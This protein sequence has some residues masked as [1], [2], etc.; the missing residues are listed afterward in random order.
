M[1][2]YTRFMYIWHPD[3][4]VYM[5]M[6]SDGM[7]TKL[8]RT[9]MSNTSNYQ[10]SESGMQLL[11]SIE[12]FRGKPYDDQTGAGI[13]DWVKGATIGYGHLISRGEWRQSGETYKKGISKDQGKAL[14]E[15]DL[16]PFVD[17][18]NVR[19]TVAIK[20][21]QFDALVI[22]A[23]NIG[24]GSF[25]KSSALK[26]VNNPSATTSYPSL[27]AAWKAWNKSQGKVMQG[28]VNRRN[29]EWNIY[30]KNVYA[31]W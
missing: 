14:F 12:S 28:L 6:Y 4:C 26:L 9:V 1:N 8:G 15:K 19:L 20:Q 31:R 29:A 22:L 18:V 21:N 3:V 13:V 24:L 23:F 10:M 27:E 17:G 7:K 5:A 30:T 2:D 16:A 11:M 25:G